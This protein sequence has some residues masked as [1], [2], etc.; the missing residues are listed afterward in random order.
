MFTQVHLAR[1]G[2][3]KKQTLFCFGA[4]GLY[5]KRINFFFF[6]HKWIIP[7]YIYS[8]KALL[9]NGVLSGYRFDRSKRAY[10]IIHCVTTKLFFHSVVWKRS[11]ILVFYGIVEISR[12]HKCDE[13]AHRD[14]QYGCPR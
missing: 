8:S 11:K 13:T 3:R 12:G 4:N 2:C 1:V 9:R 7:N 14:G 6:L 5:P 10:N